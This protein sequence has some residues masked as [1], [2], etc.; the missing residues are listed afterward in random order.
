MEWLQ[1]QVSTS[2]IELHRQRLKSCVVCMGNG[3][4]LPG[5]QR[6]KAV[7]QKTFSHPWK[8]H[9][10]DIQMMNPCIDVCTKCADLRNKQ[11]N[12]FSDPRKLKIASALQSH[13]G[14]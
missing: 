14:Q 13:V 1:T 3:V 2:V 9:L 11:K 5:L 12:T 8:L 4:V 7:G 6:V 10:P